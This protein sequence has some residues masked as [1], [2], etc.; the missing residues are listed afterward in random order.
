M[1]SVYNFFIKF[2]YFIIKKISKNS[3]HSNTS[4]PTKILPSLNK[5]Y[6]LTKNRQYKN[7]NSNNKNINNNRNNKII[8]IIIPMMGV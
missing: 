8:I 7:N 3:L 4:V 5:C 6:K 1:C 2:N